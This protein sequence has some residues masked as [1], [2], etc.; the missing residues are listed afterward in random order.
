MLFA[1]ERLSLRLALLNE[2]ALPSLA[3]QTDRNFH[4]MVLC[5]EDMPNEA[6]QGL[7]QACARHLQ[8][9]QFSVLARPY[10]RAQKYLTQFLRQRYRSGPV[11]Q[12]V[13]DDDDAFAI[14]LL[15][16]IRQELSRLPQTDGPDAMRFV[17]FADGL[18]LDVTRGDSAGARLF[19]H[20]YPYLNLGLTM[21]AGVDAKNILSIAHQ[22]TPKQHP[23]RLVKGRPMF[24]RSLHA[25]NDSRV[26]VSDRWKELLDW[27]SAPEILKRFPYL[28]ALG[29]TLLPPCLPAGQGA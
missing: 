29:R 17:S 13:L 25:A 24:V 22:Q 7:D 12:T 16:G 14:D 23:T 18:G 8:P 26:S 20:R 21:V 10:G 15:S 9:A 2:L 5:S 6:R 27:Q 11:I 4:L 1:P 28:K 3:A 19:A